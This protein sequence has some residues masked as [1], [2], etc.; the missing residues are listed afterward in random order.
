M[1]E[2]VRLA[3]SIAARA[4]AGQ[5]DKLGRPFVTHCA[6]VAE[7]LEG[8]PRAVA[9]LHDVLEKG[10]GWTAARLAEEGIA[11]D[12]IAAVEAM[13]R[14]EGEDYLDFARRAAANPLARPVK[15]NDLRDN[16]TQ[17]EELGDDSGKYHAALRLILAEYPAQEQ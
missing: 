3:E 6:R 10:P 9:L 5:Q 15:C 11:P 8:A 1:D 4:L 2:Q 14:Q 12:I 7:G 17:V 16:I 13:T